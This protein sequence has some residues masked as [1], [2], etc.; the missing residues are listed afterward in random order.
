[1]AMTRG[2]TVVDMTKDGEAW[3]ANFT[4]TCYECGCTVEY[5]D[6][7]RVPGDCSHELPA[8]EVDMACIIKDWETTD[9]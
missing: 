7:E 1:M 9:D 6:G 2:R 8:V 3:Y 4:Q 5:R